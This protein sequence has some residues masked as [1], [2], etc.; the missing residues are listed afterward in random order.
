MQYFLTAWVKYIGGVLEA[1]LGLRVVLKYL[2]ANPSTP[3]VKILY[4]FTDFLS[5]PFRKI[6]SDWV[7]RGGVVDWTAIS[8]M[9]GY[10][11]LIILIVKLIRIFV[12]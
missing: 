11:I 3:I 10:L 6:F 5:Y 8:A 12:K 2:G 4:D 7:V 9:V 1:F